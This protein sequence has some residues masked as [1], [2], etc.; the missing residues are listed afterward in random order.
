RG[1][2][3]R[4]AMRSNRPDATTAEPECA[5]NQ[6]RRTGI[7]DRNQKAALKDLQGIHACGCVGD[8]ALP[9]LR[10]QVEERRGQHKAQR[11]GSAETEAVE[12]LIEV[13][14]EEKD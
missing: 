4:P 7:N 6:A 11:A 5:R 14:P 8:Q 13:A 2:R 10:L 9:E 3:R 1:Q 12:G